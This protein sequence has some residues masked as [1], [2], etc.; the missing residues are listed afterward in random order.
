MLLSL[1]PVPHLVFR[2]SDETTT[3]SNK[4][5]LFF[6]GL[7]GVDEDLPDTVEVF[8]LGTETGMMQVPVPDGIQPGG[9]IV[10]CLV[11]LRTQK[12]SFYWSPNQLTEGVPCPMIDS[13]SGG[14]GLLHS[15]QVPKKISFHFI[16]IYYYTR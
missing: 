3:G 8:D 7:D 9:L 13:P 14:G 1:I 6:N 15:T 4:T 5:C 10:K 16:Y 11:D 12:G 2:S